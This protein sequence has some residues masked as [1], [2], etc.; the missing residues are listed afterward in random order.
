M[1][2]SLH[3]EL[4]G[5]VSREHSPMLAEPTTWWYNFTGI[6]PISSHHYVPVALMS[7]SGSETRV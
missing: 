4:L 3:L 7:Y 6:G 2:V 1:H 5:G